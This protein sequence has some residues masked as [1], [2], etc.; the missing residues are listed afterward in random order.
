MSPEDRSPYLNCLL[1]QIDTKFSIDIK[2]R[3]PVDPSAAA[4]LR[5]FH[6]YTIFEVSGKVLSFLDHF[7]FLFLKKYPQL[8]LLLA[9]PLHHVVFLHEEDLNLASWLKRNTEKDTTKKFF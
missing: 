7:E 5:I 9:T 1:L 4:V 6:I 8:I 2:I 3:V